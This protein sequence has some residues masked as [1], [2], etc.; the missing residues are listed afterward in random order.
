[1]HRHIYKYKLAGLL[2]W[3]ARVFVW[4]M[5]GFCFVRGRIF[6]VVVFFFVLAAVSLFVSL[7]SIDDFL[8]IR[9]VIV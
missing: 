3:L 2:V 4:F 1:L 8:L 5:F 6:V 9:F 7:F